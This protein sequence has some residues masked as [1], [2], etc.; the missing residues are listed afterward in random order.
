[1]NLKSVYREIQFSEV[2]DRKGG[3]TASTVDKMQRIV[4]GGVITDKEEVELDAEIGAKICSRNLDS[5]MDSLRVELKKA[6]EY[7][8]ETIDKCEGRLSQIMRQVDQVSKA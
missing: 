6:M 1:M 7:V 5:N 8:N 4:K 3:P 2:K